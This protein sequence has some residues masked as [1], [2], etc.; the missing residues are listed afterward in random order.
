MGQQGPGE[1]RRR[2]NPGTDVGIRRL[3]RADVERIIKEARNRRERPDLRGADLRGADLT[4]A[5]LTAA[6]LMSANLVGADLTYA[7]LVR[8]DLRDANL[9]RA[10]LRDANLRGAD[11]RG[12]DLTY[13]DFVRANLVRANLVRADLRD[14]NL[15]DANLRD[16]S[17]ADTSI[18]Q[19]DLSCIEGL[20]EVQHW[21][22]S[23]VSVD[24]L[25][26]TAKGLAGQPESRREEVLVFLRGTGLN[27]DM[28]ALVRSWIAKPI[29][30]YSCFISY[31]HADREFAR[32]LYDT[33]QGRGVRCW[34]RISLISPL[35]FA[36]IRHPV[37]R[38]FAAFS[39][40]ASAADAGRQFIP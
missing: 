20:A 18:T 23:S 8:A 24:T 10:D 5:H 29:E 14:A 28:L 13:A 3:T 15:R 22:S 37:S 4:G 6:H 38:V 2:H 32:L 35:W 7:N 27:D 33:L 39:E 21:G 17:M 19:I 40:A 11:L 34:L 31:S 1:P 12:A 36:G 26:R 9:V 30:F 25:E 16:A